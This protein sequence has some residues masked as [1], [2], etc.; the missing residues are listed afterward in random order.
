MF[1]NELLLRGSWILAILVSGNIH[2]VLGNHAIF[3][4]V[5]LPCKD[6]L[7]LWSTTASFNGNDNLA[8]FIVLLVNCIVSIHLDYLSDLNRRVSNVAIMVIILLL[9]LVVMTAIIC[10]SKQSSWFRIGSL[11]IVGN[12]RSERIAT[13][14]W[15]LLGSAIWLFL[16]VMQSLTSIT[17]LSIHFLFMREWMHTLTLNTRVLSILW[18]VVLS[19]N[20]VSSEQFVWMWPWRSLSVIFLLILICFHGI[21]LWVSM[22]HQ[23]LWPSISILYSLLRTQIEVI[24]DVCDI[25]HSIWIILFIRQFV[26]KLRSSWV[27]ASIFIR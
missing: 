7:L 16:R 9:K 11:I 2:L 20:C 22:W 23:R 8:T 5:A 15:T 3:R 12:G 4:S 27:T 14:L 19:R 26:W 25:G 21:L 1:I 6:R 18:F 24:D 10:A 13:G 17:A